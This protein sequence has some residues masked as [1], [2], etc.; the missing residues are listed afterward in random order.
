[1]AQI[2]RPSFYNRCRNVKA[3]SSPIPGY[4]SLPMGALDL[5]PARIYYFD[6]KHISQKLRQ[7]AISRNSFTALSHGRGSP[8]LSL[9]LGF[10]AY[11]EELL[12]SAFASQT[13]W[14][15]CIYKIPKVTCLPWLSSVQKYLF[16]RILLLYVKT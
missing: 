6:T 3:L 2:E 1:M 4:F 7:S 13:C 12:C 11:E 15:K 5:M 10:A 9:S 16:H 8:L 14:E